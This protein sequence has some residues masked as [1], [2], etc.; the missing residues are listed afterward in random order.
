[1]PEPAPAPTRSGATEQAAEDRELWDL[2]QL[3]EARG[4]CDWM[5]A[6][7]RDRVGPEV[8]EVGAGIGTFTDRL[9]AAGAQR[10]LAV[11]PE[12]A[13]ADELDRRYDADARVT[14]ARELLPDSPALS[15]R[16]G[17]VDLVLCQNVL[18]HVEA[19]GEAVAAMGRALRPGGTLA[20]LVPAHPR[21]Y[22]TLDSQYGHYRRYDRARLRRLVADAGLR[23][24]DLYSF[25]LLGVPGWVV[26]NRL[27]EPSLDGGSL[28]VY[29]ALLKL[30]RP[31]EDRVRPPWGLSLI[32]LARA[33]E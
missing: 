17:S 3:A 30:W 28:R 6:Q 33:P 20:L 2:R 16:A 9:L 4:L 10:V 8:V 26:K 29:E 19:D 11:E 21:L 18:E 23:L 12:S 32:A 1:M 7:F 22:G 14:V 5:F 31:L 25:N 24:D 27:S 15:A 13:C